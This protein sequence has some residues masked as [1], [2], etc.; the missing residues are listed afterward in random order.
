[1]KSGIRDLASDKETLEWLYD[2]TLVMIDILNDSNFQVEITETYQDLGSIGTTVL[3]EEEDDDDT[4]RFFSH[5]IYQ[6]N[7]RENVKGDVR[8]V[9]R[10]YEYDEEDMMTVFG[11]AIEKH[12]DLKSMMANARSGKKF[13]IIHEVGERLAS[14]IRGDAIGAEAMPFYS[15]HVLESHAI[16]LKESGFESW[17]YATPRFSKI[18]EETYGRSPA[19]KVLADIKMINQMKK[20]SIQSAQIAM[21]PPL[22]APHNGFLA[23]LDV[24]PFG[25][26]YK[27]TQDK[28]E[29]LFVGANVQIGVEFI[30]L[31]K[32]S[33]KEAFFTDKL[34]TLVGDRATAT[35]VIQKRDEAFSFLSPTLSRFD[36]ELLKPVI[37]RTF[38]ICFRKKKFKP[39]PAKL[40]EAMKKNGGKLKIEYLSPIAQAQKAV[41]SENINRALNATAPILGA[42][43]EVLDI[44]DGD[45]LL[46]K[47]LEVFNVPPEIQRSEADVNKIRKARQEA[48]QQAAERE[49][50]VSEAETIKKMS[51]AD[52]NQ[53]RPV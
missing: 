42:Q 3:R 40:L 24:S 7:L 12:P 11:E 5:P 25:V 49:Q 33:I 44:V 35:E 36:R 10:M 26:N 45:K 46:R 13:K 28:A 30:E 53:S 18:N 15:I 37:D 32:Q 27:R 51:E 47:N 14:E 23:P 52:A 9:S 17:P 22:Q 20:V 4:V 34:K 1:L 39:L 21:A 6:V 43:P 16:T 41:L 38:D 31:I 19:M 48:M 8:H 50:G 29:P 2:A